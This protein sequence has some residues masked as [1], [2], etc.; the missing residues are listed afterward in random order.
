MSSR[1]NGSICIT[2]LVNAANI[3]HSSMNVSQKNGKLYAN[4]TIW[5]NDQPDEHGNIMSFQL[6]SSQSG[7]AGD[8]QKTGGKKVYIGNAKPPKAPAQ[9]APQPGSVQVNM[10]AYGQV[11]GQA[12]QPQQGFGGFQQQP[13]Q[14]QQWG[15]MPQPQ[16]AQQG[17]NPWQQNQP[18]HNQTLPF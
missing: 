13:Q 1:F 18:Q 6:N 10:G 8:L 3:Q 7:E 4:V 12:A 5:L 14:N 2:D 15:Q 16:Q 9:V 17:G 11:T